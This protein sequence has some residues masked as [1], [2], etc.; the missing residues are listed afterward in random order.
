MVVAHRSQ[1]NR[2]KTFNKH[3]QSL[4]SKINNGIIFVLHAMTLATFSFS[5][6]VVSLTNS[7]VTGRINYMVN[8]RNQLDT[9]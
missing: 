3:S 2:A 8:V 6:I 5:K 9:E 7:L 4:T 1:E